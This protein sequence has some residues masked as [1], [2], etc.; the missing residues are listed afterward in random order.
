MEINS[1]P[2]R[3]EIC[4]CFWFGIWKNKI[5]FCCLKEFLSKGFVSVAQ[6]K[7]NLT[8][9]ICYDIIRDLRSLFDELDEDIRGFDKK[10]K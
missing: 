10:K 4:A 2:C 1:K 8:W 3:R 6:V 7:W 5:N 9:K